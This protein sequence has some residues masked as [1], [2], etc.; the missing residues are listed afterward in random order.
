MII[1]KSKNINNIIN[2]INQESVFIIGCS[3]CATICK[4]GGE[5]EISKL[6]KLLTKQG[7]NVIGSVILEPA[8]HKL[9]DKR[10]LNKYK[11][12]LKDIKQ[13]IT[14]SCGNGAQTISEIFEDKEVISGTDTIFLGQIKHINE[15]EKK[16]NLCGNCI[17]DKYDG[18]CPITRCPKNMLN[19]PCGGSIE[20]KCEIDNNMDCIWHL[21]YKKLKKKNRLKELR[22]INEPFD[23]SNSKTWRIKI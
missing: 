5:N 20:G 22:E 10:I 1:T 3:E 18:L 15:F 17:I 11:K 8:C 12:E 9:N 14:L 23:W 2:Q 19:G 13:I 6:E 7:I 16:C 21:I 4:T